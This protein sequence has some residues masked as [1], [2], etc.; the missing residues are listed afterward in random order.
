MKAHVQRVTHSRET[1]WVYRVKADP[2]FSRGWHFHP[3]FELTYIQAS[4]GRRLVGDAFENYR[5]GDLVLLGPNLPH[6]WRSED[7]ITGSIRRRTLHRA[8]VIQFKESFL[9]PQFFNLPELENVSEFLGRAHRGLRVAG[10]TRDE[11][12]SRLVAMGELA[13]FERLIE[14]LRIL[15]TLSR[16]KKDITEICKTAIVRVP[17]HGAQKRVDKV[18]HYLH[19]H[20]TMPII[21]TEVAS[22]FGMKPASFSRFFKK[23]TGITFIEYIGELRISHACNLLVETDLSILEVSVR[24]GFNNLSNFN[25]TFLRLK[26]VTPRRYRNRHAEAAE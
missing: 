6:T 24:S 23:T 9:G 18:F 21:Q 10:K 3:E 19:E 5:S 25:R 1:S 7:C 12:A 2:K 11:I 13:R 16:C 4:Q 8:I 14:L 22:L 20:Y 15:H 26:N 17:S